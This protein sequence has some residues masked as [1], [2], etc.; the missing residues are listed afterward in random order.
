[1]GAL[2]TLECQANVKVMR[3]ASTLY[4]CSVG[5][6]LHRTIVGLV[7]SLGTRLL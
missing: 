3:S 5:R 2:I 6:G 1:M 7:P 4:L